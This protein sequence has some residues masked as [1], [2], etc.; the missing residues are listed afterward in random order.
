MKYIWLI[1]LFLFSFVGHVYAAAPHLITS[2]ILS[3]D[4]NNWPGDN[5]KGGL[6]TIYG[7]NLG[8]SKIGS[9]FLLNQ[10]CQRRNCVST[11]QVI[12]HA[13]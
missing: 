12:Q 1:L 9:C 5:T 7:T 4:N 3:C 2:N 10:V 11:R 8:S 6:V 13:V